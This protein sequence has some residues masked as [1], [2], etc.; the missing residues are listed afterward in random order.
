[1]APYNETVHQGNQGWRMDFQDGLRL[2][3]PGGNQIT[4]PYR[5]VGE[6][7]L[8]L[9][10]VGRDGIGRD[11]LA[12][13]LWPDARS[14][15]RRLN[16]RQTLSRLRKIIGEENL[17]TS[18]SHCKLSSNFSLSIETARTSESDDCSNLGAGPNPADGFVATIEW[19]AENDPA[20]MLEMMRTTIGFT[21]AV[22]PAKLLSVL[23][24]AARAVPHNSYLHGWLQ[25]WRGFAIFSGCNIRE[26][27]PH[28]VFAA[29]AA[30]ANRDPL[31]LSESYFWLGASEILLGRSSRALLLSEKARTLLETWGISE[32]DYKI[33][34]L[35]ATALLHLNR[36]QEALKIFESATG[37]SH[38][39]SLD[40]ANHEALRALYLATLGQFA[41]AR[42]VLEFPKRLVSETGL[43][44]LKGLCCLATGVIQS[45]EE[46]HRA[47]NT[48]NS[49]LETSKLRK[50]PHF[51]LYS[52]ESLAL[53]HLKMRE[54]S[55]AKSLLKGALETRKRIGMAYTGWDQLRMKPF[56]GIVLS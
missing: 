53:A 21:S 12:E 30:E 33:A 16:L 43:Q 25:H 3:D 20:Q 22:P 29:E 31:L 46:P 2:Q 6:L 50:Y 32:G 42:E 4:F 44:N 36:N 8:V 15:T 35:R 51:V 10:R 47:I 9:A 5:K 17:S 27:Q 55:E 11:E 56:E 14:A 37:H 7:F 24:L 1:M 54:M 49:L 45:Q 39:T 52:Q 26:G 28:F 13:R 38:L 48:L 40:F 18:R 41:L 19:L 34:N 23:N